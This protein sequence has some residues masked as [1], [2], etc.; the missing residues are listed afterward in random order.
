VSRVALF[1]GNFFYS[2]RG[3]KSLSEELTNELVASGWKVITASSKLNRVARI[4]DIL[5]TIW[6]RRREY[7]IAQVEV[8]SGLA[9]IWAEMA[10]AA[11]RIL[12]KPFV[13]TLHG[14]DLPNFADR[15]PRRVAFLLSLGSIVVSPSRY[16][17]AHMAKYRSD[18]L[19]IPNS[20]KLSGYEFRQRRT[21][22]PR[23]VWMR[24]FHA[25]YNPTLAV[26]TLLEILPQW[27]DASLIMIGPDRG[28]G[29]FKDTL[30]LIERAGIGSR[31]QLVGSVPKETVPEW[32]S[33]GDIF[34]NTSH[35]DNTPISLLEALACGLCVISTNV[36]GIPYLL[37]NEHDGLLVRRNDNLGMAEAVRRVLANPDVAA[38]LSLNGRR[39][40]E[41][42]DSALILPQWKALLTHREK[43]T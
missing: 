19:I 37:E 6:T 27:P 7:S 31:V 10:A 11:L 28:D 43:N 14:G 33:K 25:L 20:I 41:C 23:L 30:D 22:R 5:T 8:Y 16:L 1:I 26:R 34:V 12:G 35:I 13:L 2:T 36:G 9:F 21:P 40:A 38:R 32:L 17:E 4:L 24:A 3:T 39:K 29:S 42:F 18:L 15:W